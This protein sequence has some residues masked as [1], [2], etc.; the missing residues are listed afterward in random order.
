[1]DSNKDINFQIKRKCHHKNRCEISF[2]NLRYGRI[3]GSK[4][5]CGS[6]AYFFLQIPCMFPNKET[7]WR[8]AAGLY[9]ASFGVFIYFFVFN[10]FGYIESVQSLKYVDWDV[11]TVTAADYTVEFD[12]PSSMYIAFI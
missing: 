3:V 8:K 9:I 6:D 1:M 11:K 2:K 12:I 10:V 7:P 4:E 5:A